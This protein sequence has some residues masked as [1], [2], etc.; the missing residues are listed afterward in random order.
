MTKTGDFHI[1]DRMLMRRRRDRVAANFKQYDIL[2]RQTAERLLERR[3]DIKRDFANILDLGCHDGPLTKALRAQGACVI[4]TD[5]SL[6]FLASIPSPTLVVDEEWLPFPAHSLDLIV[7][8][9]NFHMVNDLPGVLLQC[10]RILKPDGVLLASMLGGTSLWQLRQCLLEAELALTGG[11]RSRVAPFADLQTAA[12]LL[13][14]AGFIL[15][16]A[17]SETVKF[18]YPD[19]WHLMRD[20]RG[21]GFSNILHDRAPGLTRRALFILADALY[22]ERFAAPDGGIMADFEIIFLHSWAPPA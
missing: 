3:A 7:S 4:A 8:N 18:V 22:A 9:L 5:C 11:A 15:P 1:F 17:D 2:H 12:G 16:V 10:R 21:M 20:L 6:K 14:R 13:Q 19:I